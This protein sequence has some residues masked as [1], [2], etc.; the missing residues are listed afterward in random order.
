MPVISMTRSEAY[1]AN[2]SRGGDS[3]VIHSK[4]F[5][6]STV[7]TTP[8]AVLVLTPANFGARQ[9]AVAGIFSDFRIKQIVVKFISSIS[10]ISAG[11]ALG[12]LDDSSTAELNPPTSI[13]GVL[14]LR[15][16][17]ANF[18]AETVTTTFVYTPTNT[19][20]W[21]KTYPGSTGSDARFFAPGVLY[22]AGQSAA[23]VLTLQLDISVVYKGALDV[24]GS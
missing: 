7:G 15:C 12:V 22:G 18:T 23:T 8:S 5:I 1:E 14:E 6:T 10:S 21:Y 2:L 13:G 17:A 16:S 4:Q 11:S 19:T 3:C 24:G 9:L 20:L